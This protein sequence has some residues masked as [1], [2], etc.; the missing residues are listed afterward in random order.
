MTATT[1][2]FF[3]TNSVT[4]RNDMTIPGAVYVRN[5][6]N[7]R[8]LNN[9]INGSFD[10]SKYNGANSLG[11]DDGYVVIDES[12]LVITGG[13]ISNVWDEGIETVGAIVNA[14]FQ[15]IAIRTAFSGGIGGWLWSS[16]RDSLIADNTVDSAPRMF[17]FYRINGMRSNDSKIYFLNNTFRNNVFT[18]PRNFAYPGDFSTPSASFNF[19]SLS[20]TLVPGDARLA[21]AADLVMSGNTFAGN[22]FGKIVPA[23]SFVKHPSQPSQFAVDGGGNTCSP[24]PSYITDY[25]LKCL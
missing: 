4:A 20:T 9:T 13:T 5:G 19:G 1:D 18:N 3:D 10:P 23:P 15:G 22:N 16:V 7:N 2:S 12:N 25:P 6:L 11:A 8:F 24:P 21:T 17:D 14:T